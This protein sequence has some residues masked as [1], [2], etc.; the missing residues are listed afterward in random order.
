LIL[1]EY[2]GDRTA[3]CLSSWNSENAW[4]WRHKV[5][6]FAKRYGAKNTDDLRRIFGRRWA[7]QRCAAIIWKLE[8]KA[9]NS[10]KNKGKIA[11]HYHLFVF[12]VPWRFR[13]AR[14]AGAA[15]IVPIRFSERLLA[16]AEPVGN[17]TPDETKLN[18]TATK[19]HKE[20][21]R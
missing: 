5:A 19:E 2:A 4:L 15:N 18:L 8:F 7:Y 17:E 21:E 11:P 16:D 9:R 12:G 3:S 14:G 6:A 13:F 20:H 1:A 10:G